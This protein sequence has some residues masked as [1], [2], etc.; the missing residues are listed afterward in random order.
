[1]QEVVGSNP[2]GSIDKVSEIR[3][4]LISTGVK[5]FLNLSI[6]TGNHNMVTDGNLFGNRHTRIIMQGRWELL[7]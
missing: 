4:Q 7:A 6:F 1:M 2:V 5:A 3:I